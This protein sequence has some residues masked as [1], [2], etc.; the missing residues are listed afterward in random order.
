M[1]K[2]VGFTL[3]LFSAVALGLGM[4]W[5][6]ADSPPDQKVYLVAVEISDQFVRE[7][8]SKGSPFSSTQGAFDSALEK[9]DDAVWARATRQLNSET[10]RGLANDDLSSSVG[11]TGSGSQAIVFIDS[12]GMVDLS[13]QQLSA[14]LS[15]ILPSTEFK[16]VT[17]TGIR[18]ESRPAPS[19]LPW[20][21]AL[22]FSSGTAF[23]YVIS[24]SLLRAIRGNSSRPI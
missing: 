19:I 23:I 18:V 15:A 5:L 6:V 11:R 12:P 9:L 17:V 20:Q 22:I 13:V 10:L 1:L 24:I 4:G 8:D 2:K 3:G 21:M 16:P 7:E 14:H